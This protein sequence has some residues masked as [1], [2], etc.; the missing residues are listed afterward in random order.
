MP[1]REREFDGAAEAVIVVVIIEVVVG[2]LIEMVVIIAVAVAAA[3][4]VEAS[5]IPWL[6]LQH[7]VL[8]WPQHHVLSLHS[9][10]GE[11]PFADPPVYRI[12]RNYSWESK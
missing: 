1:A 4:R 5:E 10:I 6:L 11:F 3:S 8:P 12:I 2:V 9:V 7:V